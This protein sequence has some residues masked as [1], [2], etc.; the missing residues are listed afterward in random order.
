MDRGW[1]ILVG[2]G[3][4]VSD[5][6]NQLRP[7]ISRFEGHGLIRRAR[8]REKTLSPT[9]TESN[10]ARDIGGLT[11]FG[12]AHVAPYQVPPTSNAHAPR[13][14][15]STGVNDGLVGDGDGDRGR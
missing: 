4:S 10:S 7:R 14:V 15:G 5:C 3:G 9:A 13:D 2:Q 8:P 6:Q 12:L 11:V 1:S